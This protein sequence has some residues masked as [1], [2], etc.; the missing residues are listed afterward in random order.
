MKVDGAEVPGPLWENPT[1]TVVFASLVYSE[2]RRVR[3]CIALYSAR[4]GAGE[5]SN[6]SF[7]LPQRS[8]AVIARLTGVA[9]AGG[10]NVARR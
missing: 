8:M 5:I 10:R 1:G 6:P 3:R 9:A 7:P 2:I 4:D